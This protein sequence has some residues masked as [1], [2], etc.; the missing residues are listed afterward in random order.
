MVVLLIDN[1]IIGRLH[2]LLVHLPIGFYVL[3][4][5]IYFYRGHLIRSKLGDIILGVSAVVCTFTAITGYILA[6]YKG[7]DTDILQYHQWLGIGISLLGW[8]LW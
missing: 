3:F 8:I 1:I 7:Y 6:P 5:F 4:I 2:P